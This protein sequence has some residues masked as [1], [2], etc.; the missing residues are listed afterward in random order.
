LLIFD[1]IIVCGT[2][3]YLCPE[4]IKGVG[5]SQTADWWS[6]GILIYEMLYGIPPF[7]NTN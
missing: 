1:K 7:Y 4:I 3:E 5:H 2:P 6:F